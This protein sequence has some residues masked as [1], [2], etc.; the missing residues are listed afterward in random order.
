M[1]DN[2]NVELNDELMAFAASKIGDIK[3]N[4]ELKDSA[5]A[6]ANGSIT[7]D[8]W[9]DGLYYLI[10]GDEYENYKE[11]EAEKEEMFGEESMWAY[12]KRNGL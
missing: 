12:R 7:F 4:A 11:K 5:L 9:K 1:A 10:F 2:R 8:E 3:E 6:Y